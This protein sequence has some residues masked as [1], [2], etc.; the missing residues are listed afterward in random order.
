VTILR[1]GLYYPLGLITL[2]Y[3]AVVNAQ[4]R[5]EDSYIVA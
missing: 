4:M 3:L 2:V 5:N 1:G